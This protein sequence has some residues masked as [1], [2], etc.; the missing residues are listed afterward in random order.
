[1]SRSNGMKGRVIPSVIGAKT[2][3][4][5]ETFDGDHGCI[6][7]RFCRV[8]DNS[9]R[10]EELMFKVRV[11]VEYEFDFQERSMGGKLIRSIGIERV[12]V[13]TCMMNLVYNMKRLIAFE[14][15]IAAPG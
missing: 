3:L 4:S 7:E 5:H 15:G 14:C 11:R 12:G 1:M 10:D 6:E 13:R 2:C 8:A 9:V